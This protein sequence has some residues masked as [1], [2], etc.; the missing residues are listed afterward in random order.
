[1]QNILN[2][3]QIVDDDSKWLKI[4]QRKGIWPFGLFHEPHFEKYN[5]LM[6][7]SSHPNPPFTC[8]YIYNTSWTSNY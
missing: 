2:H 3:E 6:L 4:A 8:S 1:M 7:F 5:F